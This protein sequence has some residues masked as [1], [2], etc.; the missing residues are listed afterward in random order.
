MSEEPLIKI[1]AIIAHLVAAAYRNTAPDWELIDAELATGKY[2]TPEVHVWAL[3]P[4]LV[5]N[6]N[7]IRDLAITIFNHYDDIPFSPEETRFVYEKMEKDTYDVVQYRCAL[8][9]FQRGDRRTEV[10]KTMLKG[11]RHEDMGQ[12]IRTWLKKL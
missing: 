6:N 4:G 2:N 11:A 7:N 9:L 3:G 8:A 1:P 12:L 5:H 10:T